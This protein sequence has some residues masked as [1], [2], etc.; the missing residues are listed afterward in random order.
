MY[1]ISALI[2]GTRS[3]LTVCTYLRGKELDGKEPDAPVRDARAHMSINSH[4]NDRLD[5][6]IVFI[7]KEWKRVDICQMFICSRER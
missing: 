2:Q 6:L 3:A 4:Q 5:K 7:N 1:L